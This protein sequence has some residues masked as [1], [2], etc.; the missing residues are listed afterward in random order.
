MKEYLKR[1]WFP[2][3]VV[4]VISLH[5]I[6]MSPRASKGDPGFGFVSAEGPQKPDTIKYKNIFIKRG[7]GKIIDEYDTSTFLELS[8]TTPLVTA[9]DSIFPPD[10]LKDIDPFRYKYYVA[11]IDSL[12]HS[13]VSDSLKNAGDSIDWP[14]LDSLYTLEYNARKKAEFDA[15][16]AGL[17]KL[18]RK[19]YDIE[20]KEKIKRRIADTSPT[21]S[22]M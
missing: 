6:G 16:Y 14:I 3:L 8:D 10:S 12:V 9:R 22:N 15:W 17:S 7:S 11:I 13:I 4:C 2:L 19:K 18:E 5:A 1:I 21:A 20:Q